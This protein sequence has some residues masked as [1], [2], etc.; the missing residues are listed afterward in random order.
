MR[1]RAA[2]TLLAAFA[3]VAGCS[4]GDRGDAS[5]AAPARSS[6]QLRAAPPQVTDVCR[7]I[8][9]HT[10]VLCPTRFPL[11]RRSEIDTQSLSR[12]DYDGYLTEWHVTGFRGEDVGHVVIGGQPTRFSLARPRPDDELALPRPVVLRRVS[13]GDNRGVVVRGPRRG[14]NGGHIAVLWN[15]AERGYMVSL[16]FEA[17]PLRDRIAAAVAMA[18]SAGV[19]Q[20]ECGAATDCG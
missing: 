20:R 12:D 11:K 5:P 9:F 3:A 6:I 17:Y 2:A 19:P 16:H 4:S 7:N 10:Q 13:V 14:I 15:A 8:A 18:R 1:G